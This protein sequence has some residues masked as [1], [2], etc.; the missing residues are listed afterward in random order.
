MISDGLVMARRN[1]AHVRQ[2]PE[3][4]ID[5]TLQPL[6]F[7][8][9]FAYVFGNVI[10]IPG[11]SY[12]EYLFA[13]IAVQTLVFGLMGPGVSIANDLKEGIVDRFRSLP[14]ARSAYLVGHFIAEFAAVLLALA[15]LSV[16]GLIIGWRVHG[17]VVHAVE[18]YVLLALLAATMI[19]L[20]TLIGILVRSPDAVQGVAFLTVFPLTFIASAFVPLAGLPGVLRTFAEYNPVSTFSAAARVLFGNPV[21]PVHAPPWPLVHPVLASLAWCAVLLALVVPATLVAFRRRTAG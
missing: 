1:L 10:H 18:A 14:I 7:V 20:G 8:V 9:L 2:I 5:V 11:G 12:H 15:V 19:W 13:G 16:S 4:L 17:G 21:A 6:M 3:K